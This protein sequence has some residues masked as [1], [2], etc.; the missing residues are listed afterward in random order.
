MSSES[1][2]GPL[3]PVVVHLVDYPTPDKKEGEAGL[4]RTASVFINGRQYPIKNESLRVD[5]SNGSVISGV[6]RVTLTL[7]VDELHC[8]PYEGYR[9][10]L[11]G[12][13]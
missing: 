6:T 2:F 4:H 5:V 10:A 3:E 13:G 7:L 9:D 8:I 11:P 12:K 1:D